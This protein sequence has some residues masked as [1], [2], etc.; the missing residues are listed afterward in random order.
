[1]N[2]M[3]VNELASI[4]LLT[5]YDGGNFGDAAIQEALIENFR[6]NDPDVTFVGITLNPERTATRHNIPCFPLAAI[7]RPHYRPVRENG[8]MAN[9]SRLSRLPVLKQIAAA[10]REIR[11]ILDSH[12]LLRSVDVLAVAGGGQLD[13]EWGGPWGHPYSLFKWT[14]LARLAGRPVVFLS[15][16]ACRMDSWLSKWF[17]RSALS[18]AAYRSYR[19]QGSKQLALALTLR[20]D[21]PVVPDIAFS[22][23]VGKHKPVAHSGA[24]AQLRVALSPIAYAHPDLWPTPNAVEHERYL[25][26]LASF[27]SALLKQGVLVTLF[28]SSSPD[29]LIFPELRK[30]LD[31]DLTE[32][33]HGRLLSCEVGSHEE[34]LGLLNSVDY[35]VSSRLHALLLGFLVNKPA[36]AISYDRKVTSLMEEVGQVSRCFDIKSFTRD[37]LA[38]AFSDVQFNHELISSQLSAIHRGYKSAL[39]SQYELVQGLFSRK[40]GSM[41]EKNIDGRAPF[42]DPKLTR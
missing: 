29:D 38:A 40:T 13:E 27:T 9:R 4:A 34:L 30:R 14:R 10:V 18:C 23:P 32:A 24:N 17:F 11:H 5:P 15:V 1:M 19:D 22:L 8:T 7:S 26:E 28:S 2:A 33:D 16:G 39:Q 42:V 6:K 25:M 36:I 37:N 21:G 41:E 12:R 31:S 3:R 20:A 35:V